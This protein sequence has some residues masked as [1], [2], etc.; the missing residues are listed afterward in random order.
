MKFMKLY[1][2]WVLLFL[3]GMFVIVCKDFNKKVYNIL[4][5]EKEMFVLQS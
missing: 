3:Y 1:R 5:K 2:L 4:K